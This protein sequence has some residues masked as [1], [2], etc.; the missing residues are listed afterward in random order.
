VLAAQAEPEAGLRRPRLAARPLD[1]APHAVGVEDRERVVR[2]NSRVTVRVE[3]HPCVVAADAE[4]RPGE[5]VRSEREEVGHLRDLAGGEGGA[6]QLDH[7]ADA[8]VDREAGFGQHL[9]GDGLDALPYAGQLG[10]GR[11]ERDHDLRLDGEP[12][13]RATTAA[14]RIALAC[15]A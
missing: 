14:S 7:R 11:H 10:P 5:V 13:F 1:Q 3:E 12:S 6:G 2:Q 8:V 4:R 9:V 15:M